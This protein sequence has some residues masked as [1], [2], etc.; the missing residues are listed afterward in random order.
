MKNLLIATDFSPNATHA[1]KYGYHLARQMH[2]GVFLCHAMTIPA[3]MPQAGFVSLTDTELDGLMQDSR[4]ALLELQQELA[5]QGG[6]AGFQPKVTQVMS[7]GTVTAVIQAQLLKH[8]AEL[9]ILGTHADS[10]LG[11]FLLGDHGLQLRE[12]LDQPILLVPPSAKTAAVKRIAFASDFSAPDQDIKAIS[13]LIVIAEKTGAALLLTHIYNDQNHSADFLQWTKHLLL[14][15]I[16]RSDY[17]QIDYMVVEDREVE[18][19]LE[20]LI[21]RE[22]IDLLA[23]VHH[24][25]AFIYELLHKSHSQEMS[26]QTPVPLLIFKAG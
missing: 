5:H 12:C 22:K 16:E 14:E 25:H 2:T 10:A 15:L 3:E 4:A 21:R 1:A 13:S 24:E 9:V 11:T 26:G 18:R 8:P 20:V 6:G 17:D 7:A 23:M 19:G